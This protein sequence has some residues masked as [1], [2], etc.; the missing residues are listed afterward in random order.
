MDQ[1]RL[2]AYQLPVT[3]SFAQQQQQGADQLPGSNVVQLPVSL[4]AHQQQLASY[5]F[6][7][8]TSSP[9]VRLPVSS[10][11]QQQQSPSSLGFLQPPAAHQL[12]I[13]A[14]SVQ[15]QQLAA[16]W[17]PA[18]N[19]A[20][21]PVA[22]VAQQQ[23]SSSS[24]GFLQPPTVYQLPVNALPVQQQQ[25]AA[26]GLPV[27]SVALQQQ[28]S[29]FGLVHPPGAHQLSAN[30]S[31]IQQQQL[32]AS[33]LPVFN[34]AQ[35]PVSS[36]AQ[37]QQP[38]SLGFVHHHA[39]HQL[40]FSTSSVQQQQ[41]AASWLP[42]SN[43]A[44]L[45]VS[46]VAQ[47]PISSSL[48]FTQQPVAHQLLVDTASA[49]QQQLA[50]SW[51]PSSNVAQLSVSSAA[52]Q[53]YLTTP[54]SLQHQHAVVFPFQQQQQP[55]F[56][57]G[58]NLVQLPASSVAYQQ[59]FSP[60]G[61][62]QQQQAASRLPGSNVAQLSV[63]SVASMQQP[64]SSSSIQSLSAYQL[65]IVVTSAQTHPAANQLPSIASTIQQQPLASPQRPVL[66]VA[67]RPSSSVAFQQQL[68][69][70]GFVQQ[71]QPPFTSVAQQ[72]HPLVPISLHHHS[73]PQPPVVASIVQ[74][75]QPAQQLSVPSAVQLHN[76]SLPQQQP[77]LQQLSSAHQ[78]VALGAVHHQVSSSAPQHISTDPLSQTA[79][80][81]LPAS[82]VSLH[83]PHSFSPGSRYGTSQLPASSSVSFQHCSSGIV[84]QPSAHH[85]SAAYQL[86]CL[87]PQQSHV[88]PA[89]VQAAT[90]VQHFAQYSGNPSTESVN[91]AGFVHQSSVHMMIP[92][93]GTA[94]VSNGLS[95][96]SLYQNSTWI[97]NFKVEPFDGNPANW[98]MFICNFKAL[99]ADALPTDALRLAALREHL[100]P[101]VRN[102]VA[103]ALH[104][105]EMYHFAIHRLN[106]EFGQSFAVSEAHVEKLLHLPSVGQDDHIG[107]R[108]F[109]NEL[110]GVVSALT[111]SGN[112]VELASS[113]TLK[114]LLQKLPPDLCNKWGAKIVEMLP[115]IPNIAELDA[116]LRRLTKSQEFASYAVGSAQPPSTKSPSSIVRSSIKK[117]PLLPTIC[118]T[119]A[120]ELNTNDPPEEE[121]WDDWASS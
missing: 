104:H 16:P 30:A 103:D 120:D 23:Q 97:S 3:S 47:Q 45:P 53:Q 12:P 69:S 21:L 96:S 102:V 66:N 55:N 106:E 94:P 26:S 7:Q 92:A 91:G 43:V 14:L 33:G 29:S 105:P 71:V 34:V 58:P 35:L 65:P 121:E 76:P 113:G 10:V 107:L 68:S 49:Q 50:V 6:I 42:G 39:A 81:Q 48:C 82:S 27:S 72:Q 8:S 108:A 99:I 83:H 4:V 112:N 118:A 114:L 77:T 73:G 88:N 85:P 15:Q 52:P 56:T 57:L 24:F 54:G 63:S 25:L 59:Q 109:S 93:H 111:Y 86:P 101:A 117:E 64:V 62:T 90:P 41:L 74:Q 100:T 78:V 95:S 98:S 79:A 5:G 51:L 38:S 80:I 116:W 87:L 2:S 75:Q 40:P 110:H 61:L 36:V 17:L 22:S 60:S 13:N 46:S 70:S 32:A 89:S 119:E 11:A 9:S 20:Q 115:R 31:L 84:Q 18:P 44:Q 19:V 1:Q 67:P 37:Q 28:P